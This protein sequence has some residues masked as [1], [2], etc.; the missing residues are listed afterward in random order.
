MG[1]EEQQP[2]RSR[3]VLGNGFVARCLLSVSSATLLC[4]SLSRSGDKG[5]MLFFSLSLFFVHSLSVFSLF[6]CLTCN[7]QEASRCSSLHKKLSLAICV[8]SH[9]CEGRL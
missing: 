7:S 1:R 3:S 8:S 5:E 9:K 4:L 2:V 6:G